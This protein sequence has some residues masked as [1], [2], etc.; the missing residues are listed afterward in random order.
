MKISIIAA[1]GKNRE[2]G[3]KNKLLW[4]L[5][6]DLKRFKNL[7]TS[8][9]IVM[10]RKTYESIG[11]P[12]ANRQNIV[13]TRDPAYEAPGCTVVHS[14]DEAVKA[15]GESGGEIFVMGG[16]EIYKLALPYAN[17]MYL[18]SVD[19]ALEADAYFPEFDQSEWRVVKEEPH[20]ADEKH[21]YRFVFRVYERADKRN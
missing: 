13:I 14:M 21:P 16:A 11:K 6:D 8:H 20:A 5:S 19:A 1:I 4:H 15:A 10:G 9:A 12:L 17:K 2:L 18:T 3:F 7:T